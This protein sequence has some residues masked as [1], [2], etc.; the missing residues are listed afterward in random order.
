[1]AATIEIIED[2]STVSIDIIDQI[3]SVDISETGPQ[4]IQG[5]TG[6]AGATGATGA[7]GV[8]SVTSPI[9]NTGS[10][11]AAQI[12]IDQTLLTISPS[13]VT[14]TAAVLG[15]N[16]FTGKQSFPAATSSSATIN[17]SGGVTTP[18]SLVNGDMW[19]AFGLLRFYNGS[20]TKTFLFSD[21]TNTFTASNYFS[22]TST[23]AI[24]IIARLAA[25][26]SVSIQEWR[27][28]ADTV[29]A[30]ISSTGKLTAT[31]DGGSA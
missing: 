28:S 27:N 23:T 15:A 11:T 6:A 9:T 24:P 3:V 14:G 30:S 2:G 12:G 1:M 13:Q 10:S 16:T 31:I 22:P 19:V 21:D 7:S 8:I 4:G 25:S 5:P 17:L 20:A 26:G 18:S 29:L